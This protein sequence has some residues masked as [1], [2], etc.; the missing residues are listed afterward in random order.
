MN[1]SILTNLLRDN[2]IVVTGMGSFSAAGDSV[3]ALW[4]AAVAGRGLAAWREFDFESENL[5]FAVCNAPELDV[6]QPQMHPVR[7]MDRCVQIAWLAANQAWA[8]AQLADAYPM[9]R[10]GVIVASSRGPFSKRNESFKSVGRHKYPPSLSANSTFASLG[11]A[12]G[13]AFKIRGLGA[14]VSATCA[15]AAFAIGLAAEQILLGKADAM[16]VGGTEAPLQ[17][18]ILAQLHSAGVT[19][20]HEDAPQTCRPFDVTR[21]GLVLGEGSAFLVLESARAAAARKAD[22]LARLAG[23]GLSLD[24]SGRTGVNEDG[25]GLLQVME[26][27]LRLADFDAGKIDYINAH[28]TGTK[29][30]DRAEA[31]AVKTFFGDRAATLPCSSTKPVTGHCLGATPALEAII[32][33]EAMHH[34][35]VPP[36]AN[37]SQPDPDCP[38]NAQ[39]LVAKPARVDNVMSNSIGFWGYHGSLIFSKPM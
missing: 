29:I 20:F 16:L 4:E 8:Q 31:H 5:R 32:S 17:S 18:A 24:N 9:T 26:E 30:N 3:N 25:S 10:V 38:I 6:T 13:Q 34:Q 36:T 15:S 27:A 11:G 33:I 28:G 39:P 1:S 7:K 12:L 21:N 22:I 23:W 2:P 35:M 37:C 19:G 14:T